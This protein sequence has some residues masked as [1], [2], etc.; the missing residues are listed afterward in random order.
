M[1]NEIK[2]PNSSNVLTITKC[3]VCN[4]EFPDDKIRCYFANKETHIEKF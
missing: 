3:P 1:S 2:S 4:F